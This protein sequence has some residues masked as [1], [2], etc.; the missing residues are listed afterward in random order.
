MKKVN[1]IIN[2]DANIRHTK[3]DAFYDLQVN[4]KCVLLSR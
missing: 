1:N 4:N 2:V 3:T